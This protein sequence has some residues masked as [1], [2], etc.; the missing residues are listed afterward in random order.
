MKLWLTRIP[1]LGILLA[2]PLTTTAEQ[3][4]SA[5]RVNVVPVER[6]HYAPA[7]TMTGEVQAQKT[8]ALSFSTSGRVIAWMFDVGDRVAE[9]AALARLDAS[10]QEAAVAAAEANLSAA[11]AQL[12]QAE[13]HHDRAQRLFEQGNTTLA[14]L[15]E[16]VTA[17]RVAQEAVVAGEAQLA[18][19]EKRLEDTVLRAHAAGIITSRVVDTGQVVQAMQPIFS[20]AENGARY[21]VF[22]VHE[23]ALLTIPDEIVIALSLA[24]DR[25]QSYNGILREISPVLDPLLGTV[26]VKVEIEEA[27][28]LPLG[29]TIIGA[30]SG[31]PTEAIILPVETLASIEG[32]SAVWVVDPMSE[33]VEAREISILDVTDGSI[34]LPVDALP[35]GTLVVSKG[36]RSLRAGQTVAFAEGSE[37]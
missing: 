36:P 16:A 24:T 12:E 11:R 4:V 8:S 25:S 30:A 6:G 31:Q 22:D 7:L 33:T 32:R 37:P 15:D 5:P 19:A 1:L 35:E 21:A 20:L 18:A 17:F 28:E 13:A 27:H 14:G 2:I 23:R 10:Q 26:R 3:A 29:A 9:G 34:V